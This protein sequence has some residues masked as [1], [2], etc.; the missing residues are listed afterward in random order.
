MT[1]IR[2]SWISVVF[3]I[4]VTFKSI[5]LFIFLIAKLTLMSFVKLIRAKMIS[6]VDIQLTRKEELFVAN[7]ALIIAFSLLV[8][9][10]Y[11]IGE[12][13]YQ[14][15]FVVTVR[16]FDR[17]RKMSV[18]HVRS[19]ECDGLALVAAVIAGENSTLKLSYFMIKYD[20][21]YDHN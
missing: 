9:P 8:D 16:T 14:R 17:L 18:C 2:W 12:I 21:L 13:P 4:H 6:H 11:V 3:G 19:N 10:F 1:E 20:N 5:F 15:H 7:F